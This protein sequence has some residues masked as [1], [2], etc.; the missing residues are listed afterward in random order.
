MRLTPG[1]TSAA[2]LGE[3]GNRIRAYR[4]IRFPRYPDYPL[5][6]SCVKYI[7]TKTLIFTALR[8]P[9]RTRAAG[10]ALTNALVGDLWK[11]ALSTSNPHNN[12][13]ISENRRQRAFI[14]ALRAELAQS[15]DYHFV[16]HPRPTS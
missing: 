13:L 7:I 16:R 9:A 10:S 11:S 4:Y 14:N 8:S 15:C 3:Y 5:G 6:F 2:Y 1:A 12:T